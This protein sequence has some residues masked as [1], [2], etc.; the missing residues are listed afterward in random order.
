MA[1]LSSVCRDS[2][3]PREMRLDRFLKDEYVIV[4][5]VKEIFDIRKDHCAGYCIS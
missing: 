2:K 4:H 3:K 5:F 1:R